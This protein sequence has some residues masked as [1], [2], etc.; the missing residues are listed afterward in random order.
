MLEKANLGE[1]PGAKFGK[2]WIFKL[3]D[4]DHYLNAEIERQT[5]AK[6]TRYTQNTQ[7]RS[8]ERPRSK[9]KHPPDLSPYR[10]LL[11]LHNVEAF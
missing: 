11:G 10:H 5:Q 3:I 8:Y 2:S 7:A 9:S 4:V 6:L 1:L